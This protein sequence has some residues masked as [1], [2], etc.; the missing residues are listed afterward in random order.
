MDEHMNPSH[1]VVIQGGG[2]VGLAC[3]AWLLQ[4][5]PRIHLTLV[6]RNPPDDEQ[7]HSGDQRGIALS[8]GSK[9]L[10]DTI[11]A[12]PLHCPAIHRIHVSQAGR[13]GRALMTREELGQDALGHISRYR[14][15][16][17]ALRKALRTLQAHSPNF[18]WHH[19]ADESLVMPPA[20]CI[21]HAEGGLFKQQDW[22]ESGRDYRQAALVGTVDV[23]HPIAHQAWER[24]TDEGPLALL[25]SHLGPN[26]H[27][28]V[29]C[30]SPQSSERRLTQGDKEFLKELEHHFGQR[31][32][33]FTNVANRR[34]YDLGLNY[35]KDICIGHEV[36]IGN[37]AQTL[38]PV[39]GQGLNLGL[40]DAYL[41][42]EKLADL[43]KQTHA[44]TLNT[45]EAQ[46]VEYA[47]SRQVDRR[48]T[49]GIT[50]FLARVFTSPLIPIQ[51]SRGLALSALAWLPPVK[52]T[53][54]KQ[55]MF[56]RR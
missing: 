25:P 7:I 10:L 36:W 8:H 17:L 40:R 48:A 24:F 26:T 53:L 22:V 1:T 39:A 49:I 47:K 28:L 3:A 15:V 30:A 52:V 35:R 56:G 4:K 51:L 34:L 20:A 2:P 43:F 5:N 38:H 50:D 18:V 33:R 45:V 55:M 44:L 29:W 42:A 23:E 27:N 13:F 11:N 16:H 14:D 32:G 37:A 19:N 54:A 12:W 21:V 31:L 9:L 6:D 41:L 46:L